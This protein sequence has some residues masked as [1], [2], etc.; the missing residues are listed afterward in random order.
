MQA[1]N[2]FETSENFTRLHGGTSQMAVIL[3]NQSGRT[4]GFVL[5]M[6]AIMHNVQIL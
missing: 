3:M 6:V 1:V 4:I 5:P 2:T